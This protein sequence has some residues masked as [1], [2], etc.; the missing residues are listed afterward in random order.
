MCWAVHIEVASAEKLTQVVSEVVENRT[1]KRYLSET[2]PKGHAPVRCRVIH[3]SSVEQ[4]E[5]AVEPDAIIYG[6][7]KNW[8]RSCLYP[9]G[10]GMNADTQSLLK[11]VAIVGFGPWLPSEHWGFNLNAYLKKVRL[12][13]FARRYYRRL[14]LKYKR[15][16]CNRV[17]VVAFLWLIWLTWNFLRFPYMEYRQQFK[18]LPSPD[19]PATLSRASKKSSKVLFLYLYIG[20]C[21][22]DSV[23]KSLRARI[24]AVSEKE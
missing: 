12:V 6:K 3:L 16:C 7:Q 17:R 20:A 13:L 18:S 4:E 22:F 1:D 9:G 24:R 10:S 15:R 14:V 11:P 2:Q 8:T 21:P 23:G 19:C 5:V